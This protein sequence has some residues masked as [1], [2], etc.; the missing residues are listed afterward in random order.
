MNFLCHCLTFKEL[1]NT[2]I[3]H[4]LTRTYKLVVLKNKGK[5]LNQGRALW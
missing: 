1:R 5:Q 3:L 4:V 2:F